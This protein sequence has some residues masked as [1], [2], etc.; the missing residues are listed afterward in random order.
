MDSFL[1]SPIMCQA[2]VFW[3]QRY[4]CLNIR[5]MHVFHFKMYIS[6]VFCLIAFNLTPYSPTV[7]WYMCAKFAAFPTFHTKGAELM[8][9]C[10][11]E[12]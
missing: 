10:L 4:S 8:C 3:M 5:D 11:V 12:L 9:G 6:A 2:Y 7:T 1:N